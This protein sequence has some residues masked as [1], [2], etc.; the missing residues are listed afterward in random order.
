MTRDSFR[1]PLL[2]IAPFD[3]RCS[4]PPP[5]WPQQAAQ[6]RCSRPL[7][8]SRPSSSP[9]SMRCGRR[10]AGG[11]RAGLP[12]GAPC[13]AATIA[14]AA[15]ASFSG[16]DEQLRLA[17]APTSQACPES[18]GAAP[19][20]ALQEVVQK[21]GSDGQTE[22][23]GG[24][25][26]EARPSTATQQQTNYN[27]RTRRVPEQARDVLEPDRP[28][29]ASRPPR[30]PAA[31]PPRPADE[32]PFDRLAQ[33]LRRGCTHCD[34]KA[35]DGKGKGSGNCLAFAAHDKTGVQC[36]AGRGGRR[37]GHGLVRRA[38]QRFGARTTVP[39]P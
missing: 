11:R 14:A 12:G 17:R 20:E 32:L 3:L 35:L 1:L 19:K 37:G 26:H 4:P 33:S 34:A 10:S 31:A 2:C 22:L 21:F 16:N 15:A 36:A 6:S 9:A 24:Q 23:P 29:S 18:G 38:A 8:P 5:Q 25:V 27:F 39:R 13:S 28:S 7:R 30:L